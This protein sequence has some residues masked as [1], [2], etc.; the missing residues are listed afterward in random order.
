[1]PPFDKG[2]S[3]DV[4]GVGFSSLSAFIT[5]ST[6]P[7]VSIHGQDGIGTMSID[8]ED[9]SIGEYVIDSTNTGNS[10]V[11]SSFSEQNVW[12]TD[13]GGTGKIII[14]SKTDTTITGTFYFTATS[15]ND[16]ST[17]NVTDG[18]FEVEL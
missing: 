10:G 4:D 2:F 9:S 15:E 5:V 11:W 6:G 16:S 3:A 12:R 14:V 7:G 8:M 1:M 13:N 18:V 17:I